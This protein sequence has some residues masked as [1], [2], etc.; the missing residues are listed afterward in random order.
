MAPSL[1]IQIT[2]QEKEKY[3][4]YNSIE[5]LESNINMLTIYDAFYTNKGYLMGSTLKVSDSKKKRPAHQEC[6]VSL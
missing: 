6:N 1:W 3:F 2:D 5:T 4:I